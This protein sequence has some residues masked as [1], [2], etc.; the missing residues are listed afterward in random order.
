MQHLALPPEGTKENPI[1][2]TNGLNSDDY[3]TGPN[4][5]YERD[6]LK[7]FIGRLIG[8]KLLKARPEFKEKSSCAVFTYFVMFLEITIMFCIYWQHGFTANL[9]QPKNVTDIVLYHTISY[10]VCSISNSIA[11]V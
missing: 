6:N 11:S 4:Y 9:L 10:E 3:I 5:V 2:I 1:K 7:G 8:F